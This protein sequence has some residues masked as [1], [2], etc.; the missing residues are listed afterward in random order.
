VEKYLYLTQISPITQRKKIKNN[1]TQITGLSGFTQ[2]KKDEGLGL[3][4]RAEGVELRAK[5]DLA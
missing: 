3:R 1:G 2:I 4:L 5:K